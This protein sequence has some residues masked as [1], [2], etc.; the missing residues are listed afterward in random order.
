LS[1]PKAS[2]Q[3]RGVS[4]R[5]FIAGVAGVA[6]LAAIGGA[7]YYSQRSVSSVVSKKEILFGAAVSQ[8][9]GYGPSGTEVIKGYQ[10]WAKQVNQ[11][12][13]LLGRPV[14]L[15]LYDDKSDPSTTGTLYS[16]L[17]T[18]DNVDFLLGP[19][20]SACGLTAAPV[21]ESYK[22]VMIQLNNAKTLYTSGWEY[23]FMVIP[24]G[25]ADFAPEVFFTKYLPSLSPPVK[26]VAVINTADVYPRAV[27]AQI[28]DYCKQA[29][30]QI[31]MTQEVPK[32]VTDV[33]VIVT[34]AKEQMAD[35]LWVAGYFP[36]ETLI[37]KTAKSLDY[38]PKVV[39]CSVSAGMKDFQPT[40]QDMAVGVNDPISYGAYPSL[41]GKVPGLREFLDAFKSDYG[42]LPDQKAAVGYS[43]CQVLQNAIEGTQGVDNEKVR[44]W[45]LTNQVATVTFPWKVDQGLAKAGIKY[46]NPAT[47][48]VTQYMK[49][50]SLKIIFPTEEAEDKPIY[51]RP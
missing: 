27:I 41:V 50:G 22:K 32:N 42:Y 51:P 12:G 24:M 49:D 17:I 19:F 23:N 13:G 14:K 35:V 30:Y 48:K 1:N 21:A 8:T 47:P 28:P 2:E 37:I 34:K 3:K 38:H 40:L 7:Y 20:S 29:G 4:R 33:S 10:L 5:K 26:T 39:A 36:E 6:A 15:V 11:K 43:I 25:L 16:R 46:V 45:L 44:Q 9:G 18:V 31:V